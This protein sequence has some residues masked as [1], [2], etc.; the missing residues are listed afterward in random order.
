MN[1]WATALALVWLKVNFMEHHDEWE[2]IEM[3][4]TRWLQTQPLEGS[5]EQEVMTEAEKVG[6]SMQT[7]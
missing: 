5:T 3:K 2:M 7:T 6:L 1:V 4:A